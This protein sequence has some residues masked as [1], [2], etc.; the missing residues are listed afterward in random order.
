MELRGVPGVPAHLE[1]NLNRSLS[2]PGA[3]HV[4]H[5]ALEAGSE[6]E[7]V[8]KRAELIA[9]GIKVSP[10]VDH[11]W[12]KSIYLRDPNELII[13]YSFLTRDFTE[14]DGRMQTRIEISLGDPVPWA[15]FRD[16]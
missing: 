3:F 15:D 2:M 6:A 1:T 16:H 9:K 14:D 11:E 4:Y 7:L 13:E 5:F 8:A 12:A 10:V